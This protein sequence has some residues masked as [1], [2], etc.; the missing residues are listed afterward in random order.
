MKIKLVTIFFLT[1]GI[2]AQNIH[3]D[4]IVFTS[5]NPFSFK[6]IIT[7][8]DNQESQEVF[9]NLTFP[10]YASEEDTTKYPL[11]MGVAGSLGWAEHHLEYL[12]MYREMGIATFEVNS[13]KSRQVES[14]VGTQ[15]EVTTATMVLDSY[16]A[17]EKLS[18]HPRINKEKVAIT[19]WSLGGGVALLSGWLPAKQAI[20]IDLTFAA[21]LAIYPPCI[22]EPEILDFT[23]SPIHI[24]IGELDNWVPADACV[25]L[26]SKIRAHGSEN[27]A[28]TVY[29]NAH[30]SFD[31][32]GPVIV[33]KKGYVLTDCRLKM[34]ADGAVLMNFLDI[35][36]TTPLLQKIGLAFCAERGPSYGGNPEA[37]EK[38]FQFA[39]E[40]M[41]QYLLSDN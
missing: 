17:F 21:H 36:M 20:D 12:K 2:N 23:D 38:A 31:R 14:T 15:V 9:G 35:P 37:R 16:K 6:D 30:H 29:E 24:L 8:L 33:D 3:Q 25:D 7:D 5:A 28:V 18:V 40:F 11:V 26:V 19:G 27:I 34:R 4:K 13:F 22:V 10:E 41:G 39:R 1:A 32:Y